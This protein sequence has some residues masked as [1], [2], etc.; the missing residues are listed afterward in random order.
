MNHAQPRRSTTKQPTVST[1]MQ[2][3]CPAFTRWMERKVWKKRNGT[4]QP[5]A[6]HGPVGA[7]SKAALT[8][9]VFDQFQKRLQLSNPFLRRFMAMLQ[10]DP[11]ISAA[12]N[13]PMPIT[14]GM[15]LD[16]VERMIL[17]HSKGLSNTQWVR[18][19]DAL[20]SRAMQ[21][22]QDR[23]LAPHEREFAFVATLVQPLLDHSICHFAHTIED[24]CLPEKIKWARMSCAAKADFDDHAGTVSSFEMEM[25]FNEEALLAQALLLKC[26][27]MPEGADAIADGVHPPQRDRIR[28]AVDR[29]LS[30]LQKQWYAAEPGPSGVNGCPKGHVYT[31]A[32][33]TAQSL[34]R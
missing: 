7:T 13:T 23:L 8:V 25:D 29:A 18:P 14:K 1:Q 2:P 32:H 16:D 15:P 26:L 6:A 28:R 12:W 4:T 3:A 19:I 9:A 20:W 27:L 31:T 5:G 17:R 10:E 33:R 34:R 30:P 21:A 24:L 11:V 22:A